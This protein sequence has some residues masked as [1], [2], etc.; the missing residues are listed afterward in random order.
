MACSALRPRLR[1]TWPELLGVARH[2]RQ[3]IVE[4]DLDAHPAGLL[5][6]LDQ[7]HGLAH[8]LVDVDVALLRRVAL[9]R[10]G[11]VE[12]LGDDVVE[13]VDL[14]DDDAEELGR[15]VA[16]RQRLAVGADQQLG[17]A[18]DGAQ[19]VADLVGQAGGHLADGGQALALLDPLVDLG[20]L[21]ADA[22]PAPPAGGTR[23]CRRGRRRPRRARRG[24]RS[25]PSS[26]GP[27]SV[28][29]RAEDGHHQRRRS[30]APSTGPPGRWPRR[31]VCGLAAGAAGPPCTSR[32][33][34]SSSR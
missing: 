10:A 21:D 29:A 11:V 27:C 23:R 1:N 25:R 4:P 9:G 34:A 13:P 3:E 12:E 5:V 15:L 22:R 17:R 18:L 7:L 33:R 32:C 8:H 30:S 26:H 19:R 2:R 16:G 31:G 24:S 14:L 20:V 28:S 6:G